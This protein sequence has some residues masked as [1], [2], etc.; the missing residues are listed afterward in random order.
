[1][2]RLFLL[3]LLC[4]LNPPA[5]TSA[6]EEDP[7]QILDHAFTRY[8]A[9]VQNNTTP[10][11]TEEFSAIKST[12]KAFA[13]RQDLDKDTTFSA[14]LGLGLVAFLGGPGPRDYRKAWRHFEH[15]QKS[16]G[17]PMDVR[18]KAAN[19]M[20]L[21][22]TRGHIPEVASPRGK[23]LMLLSTHKVRDDVRERV[24]SFFAA[25]KSFVPSVSTDQTTRHEEHSDWEDSPDLSSASASPASSEEE[26]EEEWEENDSS[27]D[28]EETLAST[29]A[30][31]SPSLEESAPHASEVTTCAR[32]RPYR[33]FIA[34][35]QASNKRQRR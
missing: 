1:M 11:N 24:Q 34:Q 30:H 29:A 10:S 35:A 15:I 9:L 17:A 20:I 18:N 21:L 23:I 31:P 4:A 7:T 32:T 28:D 19:F 12:F 6:T 2:N 5:F 27:Q 33:A 26:E 25:N 8:V 3:C 13:T 16:E 22:I 14:T